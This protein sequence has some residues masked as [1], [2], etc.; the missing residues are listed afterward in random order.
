L[1]GKRKKHERKNQ[2][3]IKKTMKGEIET[4]KRKVQ[5]RERNLK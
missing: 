3:K 1:K 2:I 5:N 4:E